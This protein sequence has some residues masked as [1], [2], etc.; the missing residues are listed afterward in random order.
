MLIS[1]HLC[2]VLQSAMLHYVSAPSLM[3]V[4][5]SVP[6]DV[7]RTVHHNIS[8]FVVTHV[9]WVDYQRTDEDKNGEDNNND[10]NSDDNN[11]IVI[12]DKSNN[13]NNDI[14]NNNNNNNKDHDN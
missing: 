2:T 1:E 12:N 13:N 3:S 14:D 11:G 8:L 4:L 7:F 10:N 5:Y 6:S 9:S